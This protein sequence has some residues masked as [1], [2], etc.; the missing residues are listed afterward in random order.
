MK[1]KV[2]QYIFWLGVGGGEL[3]ED[4]KRIEFS[5]QI[6]FLFV[7]V[8]FLYAVYFALIGSYGLMG[9]LLSTMLLF[10]LCWCLNYF[11]FYLCSRCLI[12]FNGSI[13]IYLATVII[14]QDI[15]GQFFLVFLFPLIH[16]LFA[17]E[18]KRL[19]WMCFFMPV[20]AFMTLEVTQ[21]QFFY[22]VTFSDQ[23]LRFISITVFVVTCVVLNMM[24]HFYFG[25][26]QRVRN[27]LDQMVTLYPL[28]EREIEII[29]ILV[30]GKSNK[31]IADCL[32]IE[33]STV[34][35]HLKSIYKKLKVNSRNELMAKCMSV[36]G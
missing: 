23:V 30:K 33:E 14:G 25:L 31:Y 7:V 19:K 6:C 1:R 4:A 32:F 12:I 26:F 5:N 17:S 34:K 3:Y 10:I 20:L 24:F 35:N 11:R 16:M 27:S 18:Y 13:S 15:S 9:T 2:W 21:Y 8:S 36:N 29:S 22:H 28:T